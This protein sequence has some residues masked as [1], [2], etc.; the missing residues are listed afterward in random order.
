[1]KLSFTT[2]RIGIG[3]TLEQ[4]IAMAKR[5]GCVGIEFRIDQSQ[6]HG[7]ETSLDKP[8]RLRARRMLEDNYLE[9]VSISTGCYLHHTGK[10]ERTKSVA[11][12]IEAGELARDMGSKFI[13]VF[14][15]YVPEGMS[16]QDAVALV[17]DAYG[18]IADALEPM[19][20]D[21]LLEMHGQFNLPAYAI[22][23]LKTANR[24]NTGLIY[25]SDTRDITYPC[26]VSEVVLEVLPYIKHVHMHDYDGTYP[27]AQLFRLLAEAGYGGFMSAE[28]EA[29]DML[30]PAY[31]MT[32]FGEC[33]R[34]LRDA[35]V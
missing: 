32:L 27:Y 4:L 3:Q 19:G 20:V 24:P 16:A 1:M 31:V 2:Y 23:V 14:G 30:T 33:F 5:A 7:I 34:A 25:N 22:G 17:A 10:E 18:Q 15:D 26:S 35:C 8:G 13:R 29:E 11:H 28:M 6:G 21:V 12:A 9:T